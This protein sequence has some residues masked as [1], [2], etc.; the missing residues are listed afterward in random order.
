MARGAV[1]ASPSI[2]VRIPPRCRHRCRQRTRGALR[3]AAADR[4][5]RS[6]VGSSRRD[7]PIPPEQ[8]HRRRRGGEDRAGRLR[9]RESRRARH[10]SGAGRDNPRQVRIGDGAALAAGVICAHREPGALLRDG[11][12][13]GDLPRP[14]DAA[15][16]RAA[17]DR[18]AHRR[19]S[20]ERIRPRHRR[21]GQALRLAR[22]RNVDA[23]RGGGSGTARRACVAC[24]VARGGRRIRGSG[25]RLGAP[26]PPARRER[27]AAGGA[28]DAPCQCQCR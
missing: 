5:R 12:L 25:R 11:G 4:I 6:P 7:D 3:H 9:G 21:G 27:I 28:G 24:G 16:G 23:R 13:L 15:R 22:R 20:G 8:R 17:G 10:P 14:S 2:S 19:R 18:L 1:V 26:V